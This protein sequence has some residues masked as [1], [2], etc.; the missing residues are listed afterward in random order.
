MTGSAQPAPADGRCAQVAPELVADYARGALDGAA[1]WSVEAHLPGCTACRSALAAE[2]D[3]R[4]LER[5]RAVL[6]TRV[7]LPAPGLAER[8]LTRCGVPRY[9][10]RL[11]AVT[12]SLRRSWLTGVALVLAAAIGAARLLAPLAP[13]PAVLAGRPVTPLP[14]GWPGALPFLVLAP[15][16]PLAGIAAAFHARLD[17]AA[18]LATAAPVSGFRLF[19]VRSVAVIGAALVAAAL[20]ALALPGSGWLPVLV[21]LPALAVSAVGLALSTLTGPLRAATGAGA[22]WVVVLAGLGLTAGSPAA[23]YGGAAQAASLTVVIG[24]CCLVARRRHA[25]EVGWNR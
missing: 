21:I 20:A 22:G 6:L 16:L 14:A 1:A 25:L 19:C 8:T 2:L 7:A 3:Q 23:A 15:L 10:W 11:L 12:P 13:F 18:D 17:P 24:A 5:N 4:R 9:M